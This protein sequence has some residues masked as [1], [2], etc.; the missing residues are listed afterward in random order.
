[1]F[2]DQGLDAKLRNEGNGMSSQKLLII[3]I[4]GSVC[5]GI[6]FGPIA[7]KSFPLGSPL[8]MKFAK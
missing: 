7:A 1:M 4:T 6:R 3:I 2:C 8:M 5:F